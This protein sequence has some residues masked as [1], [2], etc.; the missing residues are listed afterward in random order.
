MHEYPVSY[1][2]RI[3]SAVKAPATGLSTPL[4]LKVSRCMGANFGMSSTSASNATH[5][6]DHAKA[7]SSLS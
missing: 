2:T 5:N 4:I 3:I 1:S 6:Y 7:T